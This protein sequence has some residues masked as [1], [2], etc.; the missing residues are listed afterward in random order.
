MLDPKQSLPNSSNNHN[1]DLPAKKPKTT[2]VVKPTKE[3]KPTP[4]AP[5]KLTIPPLL[6]PTLPQSIEE[7][8]KRIASAPDGANEISKHKKN[9]SIAS[10]SSLKQ[11]SSSQL[12]SPSISQNSKLA[13]EKVKV[14][15]KTSVDIKPSSSQATKVPPISSGLLSTKQNPPSYSKQPQKSNSIRDV[16]GTSTTQSGTTQKRT[17]QNGTA[18]KGT[19]RND[20]LQNGTTPNG[21]TQVARKEPANSIK[22]PKHPEESLVVKLKYIKNERIA[23]LIEYVDTHPKFKRG[24]P[25]V[26]LSQEGKEAFTTITEKDKNLS[27]KSQ[28]GLA[29]SNSKQNNENANITLSDSNSKCITNGQK[30][31]A[32][33]TSNSNALQI[34]RQKPSDLSQKPSV[35]YHTAKMSTPAETEIRTPH[36]LAQ[37]M[38]P[39]PSSIEKSNRKE[40]HGT[41]SASVHSEEVSAYKAEGHRLSTVARTLK[42][43]VDDL[44]KVKDDAEDKDRAE[45]LIVA[46]AI[47]CVITYI[48]AF[49][50]MDE[51]TK[52]QRLSCNPN[53]WDSL[54]RYIKR[55]D[56]MTSKFALLHGLC[57]QLEAAVRSTI[58]EY[59]P[60]ETDTPAS[61]PQNQPLPDAT[62]EGVRESM[63][64]MWRK[65]V[66]AEQQAWLL[67]GTELSVEKTMQHFPKTWSRKA[68]AP[69]VDGTFAVGSFDGPFFLPL[70]NFS[71]VIEAGRAALSMLEEWSEQEG[72]GWAAQ[73]K[74]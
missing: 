61:Q 27:L 29:R 51:A 15:A 16:E 9:I 18:Q 66:R 20:T 64:S 55:I 58:L 3:S 19:G 26:E 44:T 32:E 59:K 50:A 33:D 45:K 30:R 10:S 36:G 60:S 31:K 48:F 43:T 73:L 21:T 65:D 52:L 7:E 67:G 4:K 63:H 57:S 41:A 37:S 17:V 6:S 13:K 14:S 34:K 56:S 25:S 23:R 40:R 11:S 22:D 2:P 74:L 5:E 49:A 1:V 12:S 62:P 35:Y 24:K 46:T 72:L 8:L 70:S 71:P 28:N 68:A 38:T 69:N 39:I 54:I 42:H 47:E 53:A